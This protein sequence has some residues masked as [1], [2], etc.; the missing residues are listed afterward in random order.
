MSDI[1]SILKQRASI[2]PDSLDNKLYI[3]AQKIIELSTE[4]QKRVIKIM[5]EFDLHDETHLKKVEEN[6]AHLLGDELLAELSSV[7]L[8]L[9]LSA[10]YLHDC[11]MAPADWELSLMGM[12]EGFDSHTISDNSICN[13]GKK[14][15]T[16]K[17]AKKLIEQNKSALYESFESVRDWPFSPESEYKLKD[18]LSE[19]LVEYQAF[20]N[21]YIDKIKDSIKN[22]CFESL[23][24]SIRIDFIR[25]Y[26]HKESA[27]Y[28]RNLKKI[29]SPVLGECWVQRLFT[30]LADI[31][32]SHGENIDFVRNLNKDV[33]YIGIDGANLQF[34][35]MMLRLGDIIHYSSD[36]APSILRNA[37]SFKSEYSKNEW[38]TKVG[39]NYVIRDG[40]ISF[41]AN[42]QEPK[43][44]YHLQEYLD[45]IDQEINSFDLLKRGWQPMY[46]LNINEVNR[47]N[48]DYNK[49]TFIPVKDKK[50]TLS[51][52]KII[53]LL[54][55][56]KLYK[57]PF[58]TIRE[59]YQNALDACRCRLAIAKMNGQLLDGDIEFGIE[60][61]MDGRFLYCKDNGIG[62]DKY[63]I[64]NYLLKIGN[65]FYNSK[66]FYKK[67]SQWNCTYTPVSQFGIGILSCF[68]IGY[69]IE[70]ITKSIET[71]QCIVCCIDGAKEFFYYKVPSR[72]DEEQISESG[73]IVKVF[74]RPEYEHRINNE[75]LAKLGLTLQYKPNGTFVGE[76]E[77]YNHIYEIWETSLYHYLNDYVSRIPSEIKLRVSF[78]DSS[79]ETVY[80][81]PFTV[82]IG[83]LGIESEDQPF[84]DKML[85]RG[86][87]YEFNGSIVELQK[88]L[89]LYPIHIETE[90]IEYNSIIAL[91]LPG[92]QIVDKE[93]LLFKLLKVESSSIS[94][95][96]IS[97]DDRFTDQGN[98]LRR[99]GL[100]GSVNFIG[101]IK[102]QLSVDRKEIVSFPEDY[103]DK[104][105]EVVEKEIV[106]TIEVVNQHIKQYD[107]SSKPET[108]NLIWEYIFNRMG[109][110]QSIFVNN[111][112]KS[113]LGEI[114][115]PSV[116]KLTEKDITI[117]D[118]L[119]MN[120]I[121][122]YRYDHTQLDYLSRMLVFALLISAKKVEAI[123]DNTIKI[124]RDS[125][126]TIPE[127]E[128]F[129][130]YARYLVPAEET[131]TF[132][133][134]DIIS[135]LY[136]LVPKRLIAHLRHIDTIPNSCAVSVNAW[137]NC[138]N[139]LFFQDSRLVNP[140][141]GIY[142]EDRTFGKTRD[143]IIHAFDNKRSKFQCMDF[144]ESFPYNK[145][146]VPY[147][148]YIS[149]A[150]LTPKDIKILE[151]IK[152]KEAT[153]YEGVING[154]TL[155]VTNMDI[156]NIIIRPGKVS[157]NDMI[158]CISNEFWNNYTDWTFIFLDGTLMTKPKN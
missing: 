68:I 131:E 157:R 87:F 76:F 110:T 65:S 4:H 9:L 81:K 27:L 146:C 153:Y 12:T 28:I 61:G 113:E 127:T 148:A 78:S 100:N 139:E 33:K 99:L 62:M 137:G 70:I 84:I 107:L 98:Y 10:S 91:P 6:I 97:V 1:I 85:Q 57:D 149:P 59:L 105:R 29:A 60:N 154:W 36:R 117:K 158:E 11:G 123:D 83:T 48:V 101:E 7:E 112:A 120:D 95:D 52:N 73:T 49:A 54:M 152:E 118:L 2:N 66:D 141:I 34:I 93:S 108:V 130:E 119:S 5:P 114:F 135:N 75:P 69:R 30:D 39:L 116:K 45:W 136:P 140:E 155:L 121:I 55:G 94:V 21:G 3:L 71:H 24:Q 18:S 128:E 86:S 26:H 58:S 106:D 89:K 50:F 20:R 126:C 67:Q 143:S 115:W 144:N 147:L 47:S 19:M 25:T 156:D 102:P 138:Y 32:R 31:C 13:D 133:E 53:E 22:D 129:W 64:E 42:C 40:M 14:T 46:Q 15:L 38:L 8:F 104:Y 23:N 145:V 79:I 41:M 150:V 74:L 111:L 103:S 51:Q 142:S 92:M 125:N 132:K 43:D 90:S 96:G 37:I 63:V 44:Y 17:D 151:S 82:N 122:L 80:N 35:S 77:K 16:I 72:D 134:Y 56:V 109:C 88:H 124:S